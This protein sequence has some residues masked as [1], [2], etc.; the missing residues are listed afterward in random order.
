MDYATLLEES[1]QMLPELVQ[2]RR[3]L[4]KIPEVGNRLPKTRATVL[5]ALEGLPLEIHLH[6]TT[7]G[8][9]AVL[10]GGKPGPTIVLRGDMDALAMPEGTGLDFTSEH[11]GQMHACG[12]DLH[13]S[14]LVGAARMLSARQSD[15]AGKVLF[16][17]QP[18][19]EGHFGARFMLDEGLLEQVDPSPSR[20]FAIH[21]TSL[22]EAGTIHLK[23]GPYMAAADKMVVTVHGQGGHASTPWNAVDPIPVA[24]EIITACEVALTRTVDVFDPAVVTFGQMTAGTAYN[25]I[26][27]T[28]TL[29]GTTRS[30][31]EERRDQVHAMI[32]RVVAG[33][34]AAHGVE[35]TVEIERGYPVTINDDQVAA[36]VAALAGDLL[37]VDRV[38]LAPTPIMGA[39]DWSYVLQRVPGVMVFLGSCPADLEPGKAP[40]NHS[41]LVRFDEESMA[42]GV[43]L[44][45]AVAL[46][47]LG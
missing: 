31:S 4:H 8:I 2:L 38:V 39:E 36:E 42:S 19:E 14:M 45:T 27:A 10:E 24:A 34:A 11:D 37:G 25:V 1:R 40:V 13:T 30:V 22:H 5:E 16:M 6:E 41:N 44:H 17:F 29:T 47:H 21:V 12:H 20:A 28:A 23:P 18:G 15:L 7:S 33:V 43:A 35:A 3:S 26:P 32:E 46:D 9:T